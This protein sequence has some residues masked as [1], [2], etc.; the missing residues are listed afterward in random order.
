M[1]WQFMIGALVL[2]AALLGS[3][4]GSISTPPSETPSF[5]ELASTPCVGGVIQK[6]P[7]RFVPDPRE[8]VV[9]VARGIAMSDRGPVCTTGVYIADANNDRPSGEIISIWG[10]NGAGEV[11]SDGYWHPPAIQNIIEVKVIH[12]LPGPYDQ[13]LISYQAAFDDMSAVHKIVIRFT[14]NYANYDEILHVANAGSLDVIPDDNGVTIKAFIHNGNCH[15]CGSYRSFGMSYDKIS[16]QLAIVAP[17]ADSVE[18]YKD[19][20]EQDRHPR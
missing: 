1:G 11:F 3:A 8:Q 20:V 18:L 17:N 12:I 4:G 14:G 10:A 9:K 2:A 6:T 19:L 13:I 5:K 16:D 15:S 7:G